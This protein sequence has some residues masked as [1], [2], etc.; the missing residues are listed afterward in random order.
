MSVLT[1]CV[2]G[3]GNG[4]DSRLVCDPFHRAPHE[5]PR[6][7]G[8]R[9]GREEP[10]LPAAPSALDARDLLFEQGQELREKRKITIILITHEPDIAAYGTRI[11]AVRDGL[12]TSDMPNVPQRMLEEVKPV[13]HPHLVRAANGA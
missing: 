6:D 7:G 9:S 12:I 11:I 10:H 13:S 1:C 3:T 5:V 2:A 8:T 4:A